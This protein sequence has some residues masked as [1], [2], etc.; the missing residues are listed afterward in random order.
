MDVR[1]QA[2]VVID[3]RKYGKGAKIEVDK[4]NT[5]DSGTL[6]KV[7]DALYAG[8]KLRLKKEKIHVP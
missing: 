3:G 4:N 5:V 2:L 7:W 6:E 8:I 1:I